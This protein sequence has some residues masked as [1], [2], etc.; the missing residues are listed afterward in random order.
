MPRA[1]WIA[2]AMSCVVTE[3]NRRPSSPACWVIVSTVLLSSSA[4]LLAAR[5][6][7]S[8]RGALLGRG[9]A[10]GGVEGALGRR[11]GELARDQVVAQV[12]L[13]D[14]DDGPLLA[15]RLDVLEQDRLGHRASGPRDRGRGRRGRRARGAPRGLGDVGQQ[16]ELA[17]ALDGGGDLALV[18][19]A[20]AA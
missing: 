9:A 4:L 11:L 13:G 3:P 5:P 6:T 18:A 7:A 14:V 1:S 19:A 12:A 8:L 10:L 16:R 2:S 20:G 15:E 17:R